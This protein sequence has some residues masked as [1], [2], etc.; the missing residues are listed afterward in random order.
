MQGRALLDSPYYNK[1]TAFTDAERATFKLEGLLP[2]NVQTLQEQHDRAYEQYQKCSD[3]LSKNT[4]MTS[5]SEQNVV[6][7]YKL[8]L[9][10]LQEIFPVVYTPT[11]G[12]AIE[13]YS[14]LFR[15]PNGCFLD[16]DEQDSMEQRLQAAAEGKKVRYIVVSD[17]EQILGLGD[18]GVGGI[19]ISVAKLILATACAGVSPFRTLP[20][21]LDVGTDNKEIEQSELYL[22]MKKPRTRGKEYDDHVDKFVQTARRLFPDVY[23]HFEVHVRRSRKLDYANTSR[24]LGWQMLGR[25]FISIETNSLVSTMTSKAP[26]AWLLQPSMLHCKSPRLHL[27]RSDSWSMVQ[28]ALAVALLSKLPMV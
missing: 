10:H 23:I 11:E 20:V 15:R 9:S 2:R 28:A 24:T 4:F 21:V 17:G 5:M 7:F 22:G 1:G 18:Q 12:E 3:S 19:L 8:L 26:A 14:H 25:S 13:N 6:L 16:I 27:M